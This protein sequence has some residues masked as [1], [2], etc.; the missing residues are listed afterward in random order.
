MIECNVPVNDPMPG[1][2]PWWRTCRHHFYSN[3]KCSACN[4][5]RGVAIRGGWRPNPCPHRNV[6]DYICLD[7]G[8]STVELALAG[9]LP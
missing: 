9:K 6:N 7:C 4:M 8:E 2:A 3:G 5:M 1:L